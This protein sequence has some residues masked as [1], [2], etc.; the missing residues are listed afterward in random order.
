MGKANEYMTS[1]KVK[2]LK[3]TPL[4]GQTYL[5]HFDIKA[6]TPISIQH[7]ISIIL[8]CDFSKYSTK[9]SESFRKLYPYETIHSVKKRNQDYW[10]QSKLF[11]EVVEYYGLTGS[12]EAVSMETEFGPFCTCNCSHL[13][14]SLSHVQSQFK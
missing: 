4:R 1:T 13:C 11:K 8:Y 7:I 9:F 6:G 3:A 12:K 2:T 5:L 14:H 10:W